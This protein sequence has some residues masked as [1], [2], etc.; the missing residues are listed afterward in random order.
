MPTIPGTKPY[1]FIWRGGSKPIGSGDINSF[2]TWH[3]ANPDA[4]AVLWVDGKSGAEAA[5]TIR[6]SFKTNKNFTIKDVS[7]G[8][9]SADAV[10]SIL[11]QAAAAGAP[12]C[13]ECE[14][15]RKAKAGD[16]VS[17]ELW[18]ELKLG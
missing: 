14:K 10:A 9:G 16:T 12:F 1:H 18:N 4:D 3:I 11:R 15:R 2:L 8:G 6:E 17:P 7:E 13:E 5:K